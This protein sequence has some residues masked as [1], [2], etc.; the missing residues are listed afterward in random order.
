LSTSSRG[1]QQRF[2]E[3]FDFFFQA[4]TQQALDR[5]DGVVPDLESYIALRRDTS[6]CKPCWALIEYANNLDI[7]DD[8]MEHPIIRDL[9]EAANDLVTWSNVSSALL[10]SILRLLTILLQDLFSYNVEQSKG[11]THN[12]IPVIMNEHGLDL[13]SAV[14]FVG[15]L[16]KQSIDRFNNNRNNLPSWS[17]KI[18]KDVAVYVDGLANWIVG[19]LHWSFES[20]RYFGKNGKDVKANR[21]VNLLPC[22]T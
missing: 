7:P 13:Q 20:Q 15:D 21:I 22:R 9:G 18:D 11:D 16:C 5:E 12:M 14:D 2:V 17:T 4:V 8:V 6:G 10:Y 1:S 3:T 19:S